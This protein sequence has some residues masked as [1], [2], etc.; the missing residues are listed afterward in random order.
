MFDYTISKD[1]SP[2]VFKDACKKISSMHPEYFMFPLVV[3]VDGSTLQI[4]QNNENEIK[5]YDDYDVG[6]VYVISD[7]DLNDALTVTK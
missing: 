5:V 4:F 2:K 3:D 6:A 7:V 1:N